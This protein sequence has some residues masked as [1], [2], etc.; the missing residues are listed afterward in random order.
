MLRRVRKVSKS[1]SRDQIPYLR[2]NPELWARACAGQTIELPE[3]VLQEF[4]HAFQEDQL[5]STNE[6]LAK[7]LTKPKAEEPPS[8]EEEDSEG[9]SDS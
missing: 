3:E 6:R 1:L 2:H 4:S 9:D 8:T 5:G 7:K